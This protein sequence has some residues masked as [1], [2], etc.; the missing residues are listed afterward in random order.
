VKTISPDYL[1]EGGHLAAFFLTV[2]QGNG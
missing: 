1:G 2:I